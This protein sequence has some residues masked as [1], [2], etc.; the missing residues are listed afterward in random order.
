LAEGEKP[1]SATLFLNFPGSDE[2]GKVDRERSGRHRGQTGPARWQRIQQRYGD[3][4]DQ[5]KKEKSMTGTTIKPDEDPQKPRETR[6]LPLNAGA[7]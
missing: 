3:Q 5:A 2:T 7:V 1:Q 4:K 6:A